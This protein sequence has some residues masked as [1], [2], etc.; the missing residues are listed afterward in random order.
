MKH[1]TIGALAAVIL[2]G[3]VPSL[4][5]LYT[6]KDLVD[7]P[8]L[9][10]TW[11]GDDEQ[12]ETWIFSRSEHSGYDLIH[13]NSEDPRRF[14]AHLV[15]LGKER[16]LDLYPEDPAIK[17]EVFKGHWLPVHHFAWIQVSADTLQISWLDA[18]K[19]KKGVEAGRYKVAHELFDKG[20]GLLLTA[21]TPELQ[22][23]IRALAGE[24]KAFLDSNNFRRVR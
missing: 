1:W 5:P 12:K 20:D 7:E 6:D 23:L 13:I 14:R 4:H 17:N 19:L 3:C 10:G 24:P 18:D 22:N 11:K 9:L 16:Y 2:T 21:H 15:Q 8:L